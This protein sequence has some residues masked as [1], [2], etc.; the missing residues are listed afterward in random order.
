[1]RML[2]ENR[3]YVLLGVSK[4]VKVDDCF[5]VLKV[6]TKLTSEPGFRK[7]EWSYRKKYLVMNDNDFYLTY[8]LY[9]KKDF[10]DGGYLACMGVELSEDE[11]DVVGEFLRGVMT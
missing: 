11:K 10:E 5:F 2:S 4:L 8:Y 1:M 6:V 7:P 9:G 3:S